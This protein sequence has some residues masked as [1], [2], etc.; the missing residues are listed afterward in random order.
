MLKNTVRP[1]NAEAWVT[2]VGIQIDC[3]HTLVICWIQPSRL[4]WR[5]W[6]PW[7]T[8]EVAFPL[9]ILHIVWPVP[10]KHQTRTR[11]RQNWWKRVPVLQPK[12]ARWMSDSACWSSNK[13]LPFE[14]GFLHWMSFLAFFCVGPICFWVF[15]KIFQGK[16][17]SSGVERA[18]GN[19]LLSS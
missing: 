7:R 9:A 8:V 11:M 17:W 2:V 10:L 16:T 18:Q 13:L 4:H 19:L 3:S 5:A 14:L 15:D 12:D 6:G 1:L